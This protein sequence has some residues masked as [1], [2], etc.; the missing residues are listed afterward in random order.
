MNKSL[1]YTDL[2]CLKTALQAEHDDLKATRANT[3]KLLNIICY[4]QTIADF[5]RPIG[6][7]L[8]RSQNKT[9]SLFHLVFKTL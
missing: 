7:I 8:S 1:L 2:F 4:K 5:S 9:V 6:D 3:G